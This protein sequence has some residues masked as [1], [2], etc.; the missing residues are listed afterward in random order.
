MW[1]IMSG[2]MKRLHGMEEVVGSIPTRSTNHYHSVG[3]TS[4]S[5]LRVKDMAGKGIDRSALYLKRGL[6]I[7]VTTDLAWSRLRDLKS[8][9]DI[10]VHRGGK[11]GESQEH[12]KTV[13][14]LI[15]KYPEALELRNTDGFHEQIWMSMNLCRDLAQHISDFFERVFLASGLPNRHGI[16]H[17]R[18]GCAT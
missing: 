10:I 14:S 16:L 1:H 2:L 9:R 13:D 4:G 17:S 11:S 5:K 8:L 3:K 7:D 12:Q 18:T 6:S 15:G